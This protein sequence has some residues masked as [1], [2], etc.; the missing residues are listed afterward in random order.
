MEFCGWA[1]P[2]QRISIITVSHID[3]QR[4]VKSVSKCPSHTIIICFIFCMKFDDLQSKF[5][6]LI[7]Y[8][9]KYICIY[10]CFQAFFMF[11]K[12]NH[13]AESLIYMKVLE[14]CFYRQCWFRREK[15][16]K[17]FSLQIVFKQVCVHILCVLRVFFFRCQI[18]HT[19]LYLTSQYYMQCQE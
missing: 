10:F 9:S 4:I 11:Q 7:V 8:L 1:S 2:Q 3:S 18:K 13:A 14:L 5:I 12:N 16:Q 17:L 15:K 19:M 6:Y